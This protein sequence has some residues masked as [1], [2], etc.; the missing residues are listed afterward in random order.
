MELVQKRD[1]VTTG[2]KSYVIVFDLSNSATVKSFGELGHHFHCLNLFQVSCLALD[3]V[4]YFLVYVLLCNWLV[5]FCCIHCSCPCCFQWQL[6]PFDTDKSE[7]IRQNFIESN[8]FAMLYTY[9]KRN[10]RTEKHTSC[11]LCVSLH[12]H[13]VMILW[14]I[15]HIDNCIMGVCLTALFTK[16]DTTVNVINPCLQICMYALKSELSAFDELII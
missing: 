16:N 15:L 12:A 7:S 3:F 11:F 14:W 1:A 8:D 13:Y 4:D 9:R 2:W 6:W 5:S 10:N